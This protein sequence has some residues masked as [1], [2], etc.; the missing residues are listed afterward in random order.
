VGVDLSSHVR[1]ERTR[2]NG[3]KMHQGKFSLSI[4]KN[5]SGRVVRYWN[6][7]PKAVVES[8]SLEGLKNHGDVA[9]RAMVSGHSK[10]DCWLDLVILE[11]FSSLSDST[12]LYA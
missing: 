3:L 11:V 7:L 1:R 6:G 8:P 12:I 9:L 10:M 5:F 2:G 4:R